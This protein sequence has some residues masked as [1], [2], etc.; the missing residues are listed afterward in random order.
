M[1]PANICRVQLHFSY[2]DSTRAT[3]YLRQALMRNFSTSEPLFSS[4]KLTPKLDFRAAAL[5]GK[6]DHTETAFSIIGGRVGYR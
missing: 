1:S 5:Y 4:L 3:P 2:C 6:R